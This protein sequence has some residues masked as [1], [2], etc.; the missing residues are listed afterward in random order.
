MGSNRSGAVDRVLL[1]A[2]RTATAEIT[3]N[4]GVPRWLNASALDG[5]QRTDPSARVERDWAGHEGQAARAAW[6]PLPWMLTV[7]DDPNSCGSPFGPLTCGL[8]VPDEKFVN[9]WLL[10]RPETMRASTSARQ[11]VRH[12]S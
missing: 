4:S 9:R 2:G 7:C 11:R 5:E 12:I 6:P 10:V 1:M 3:A 8:P